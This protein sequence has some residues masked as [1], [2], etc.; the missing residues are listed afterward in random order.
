MVVE[1]GE[2]ERGG[3]AKHDK[4]QQYV[5]VLLGKSSSS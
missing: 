2:R 4:V 5:L 3:F 1:K